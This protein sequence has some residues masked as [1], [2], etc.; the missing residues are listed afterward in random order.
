MVNPI[1]EC[2]RKTWDEWN[3]R[4]VI[5]LSLSLQAILFLFASLR[6]GTANKLII[7]LIWSVY[8]L[9]DWSATFALGLISN[10][11]AEHT[12]PAD[13]DS[14]KPAEI[15]S[16]LLAFWTPFLFLHL[17]GPDNIT[18]FALEDNE[19]W[20]RHFVGLLF[21][22]L[23]ALYIFLLSLPKNKLVI[24]TI[25]MFI[26]GS[27]KYL[28]RTRAFYLASFDKFQDSAFKELADPGPNYANFMKEYI[29]KKKDKQ[30]PSPA[31]TTTVEE[32]LRIRWVLHRLN[33]L[34]VMHYAYK[35]FNIF[36]GLVVDL[37]L[38]VHQHRE[39]RDFFLTL[40]PKD[41]LRV[42]E[43]ELNLI[44][45][46]FYTKVQV[47]SSLAGCIC[48]FISLGLVVV[49]LTM[50]HFKVKKNHGFDEF[51][52]AITYALF[53]V[54]IALD[55]M[56]MFILVCYDFTFGALM[57][58]DNGSKF[59]SK[60]KFS[61]AAMLNWVLD[62]KTPRRN[63]CDN[64][65]GE[66]IVTTFLFGRWSAYVSGYNLIRYC[67]KR[68]PTRAHKVRNCLHHRCIDKVIDQFIRL[69]AIAINK[70]RLLLNNVIFIRRL[71]RIIDCFGF[72]IGKVIDL[73]ELSNFL[74]EIRYVSHEPLT[75]ELW[76][77]IFLELQLKARYADDPEIAKKISS[78]RGAWT[79]QYKDHSG[80]LMRYLTQV[81]FDESILLWH[82]ATELLYQT[83][84]ELLGNTNHMHHRRDHRD[85]REYSKLLSDYML[86]L[87]IM[88]PTVISA[89]AGFA[90]LRF[91]ET[92]A[93]L[94]SVRSTSLKTNHEKQVFKEIR[95]MVDPKRQEKGDRSKSV[96]FD[97]TVLAKELKDLVERK[98][99]KWVL[100]SKVW[101]EM[102]S[103]AACY[104]TSRTHAQ[105]VSKGGELLTIVWFL[106]AHFGLREQ[107]H[108]Y[109]WDGDC[110]VDIP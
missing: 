55:T 82:I 50:F 95:D 110:N 35:Y 42:I 4:G 40:S 84:D 75:K 89:V 41:A 85:H 64:H 36:K 90:K 32:P 61:I 6:K 27:V 17:G 33:N 104:S 46:V 34:E 73:L 63:A 58:P 81:T 91:Q 83:E 60:M 71:G 13:H 54:A 92:C 93:E 107:L 14:S 102:L 98:E 39:C 45:E 5:L 31:T 48:R 109:N 72:M 57:N 88:N 15:N 59:V 70:V 94:R 108:N 10:S 80:R 53:L 11:V 62:L 3:I 100:I 76:E 26:A 67:L 16:E 79:L 44:Y 49:A 99:D 65:S 19:L 97:A 37:I 74:N 87:L 78:S 7:L 103:Y 22:A 18:A 38:E 23:A 101:V 30:P 68:R 52:V 66:L 106:M 25:L 77:F 47:V 86:Y 21:Q 56:A 20:F 28:E 9:A 105:N 2:V 29:S 96:L 51:D 69:L 12:A 8:L 1:P 24:P 43:V